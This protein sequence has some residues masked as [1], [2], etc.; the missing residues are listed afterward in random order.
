LRSP[1]RI[2]GLP[3]E[4]LAVRDM[5]ERRERDFLLGK[6]RVTMRSSMENVQVGDFRIDN[7]K[8]GET[9]E[10]PRW[11]AEELVRLN[12]AEMLEEP[13]ETEIFKALSREKMMG[14]LQLSNITP[15]FFL[16]MRRRLGHLNTAVQEGK[17]KK[18][19]YERLRSNSYDLIGL[20]LGKLLAL[21][22]SS[23]DVATFSDKLTPEESA[24]FK[25]SQ[26]FSKEWKN[27]LLRDGA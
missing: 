14:P 10:L 7:V 15:D 6:S 9:V 27:A 8:D 16:K 4:A 19:D 12:L 25:L 2:F 23:A 5:L 17:V 26:S 18:E 24:F 1:P 3:E 22:S 20:R 21:S 11:A 13:F